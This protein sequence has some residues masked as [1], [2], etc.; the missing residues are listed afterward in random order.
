M[1]NKNKNYLLE[2]EMRIFLKNLD[3]N[4]AID[5][6]NPTVRKCVYECNKRNYVSGYFHCSRT[7]DNSIV[8]DYNN[9]CVEK[10]GYEFLYKNKNWIAIWTLVASVLTAIGVILQLILTIAK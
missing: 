4:E 3:S 9:P 1:K 5:Y 7:A 8:F 10:D 2:E 6:T